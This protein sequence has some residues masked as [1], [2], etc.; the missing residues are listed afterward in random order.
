MGFRQKIATQYK[1]NLR[2]IVLSIHF[3]QDFKKIYVS[4]LSWL[5][6]LSDYIKLT[7][8]NSLNSQILDF[9]FGRSVFS[10]YFCT[11]PIKDYIN[12]RMRNYR[13]TRQMQNEASIPTIGPVSYEEAWERIDNGIREMEAGGGYTWEEVKEELMQVAEVYA[14]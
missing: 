2:K 13:L 14:D 7:T 11:R 10:L 9:F 4:K 6:W 5:S 12:K 1:Q 8:L 3:K